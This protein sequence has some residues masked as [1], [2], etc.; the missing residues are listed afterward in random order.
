MFLESFQGMFFI[1]DAA[2]DEDEQGRKIIAAQDFVEEH[3]IKSVFGFGGQASSDGSYCVVVVFTDTE[4]TNQKARLNLVLN[5]TIRKTIK[6][7]F[8]N[9]KFFK[10]VAAILFKCQKKYSNFTTLWKVSPTLPS[11]VSS[12]AIFITKL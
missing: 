8:D 7:Y 11:L 9:K 2:V 6:P 12:R 4:L 5:N 10:P 3:N 1:D